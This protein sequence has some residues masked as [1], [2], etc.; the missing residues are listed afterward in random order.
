[1]SGRTNYVLTIIPVIEV[2]AR[3]LILTHGK[4]AAPA[5]PDLVETT[6]SLTIILRGPSQIFLTEIC[7]CLPV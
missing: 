6:R 1:M 5:P 2:L 3:R 4:D 7:H